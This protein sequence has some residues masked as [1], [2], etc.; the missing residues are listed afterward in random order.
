[1]VNVTIIDESVQPDYRMFLD[2]RFRSVHAE[3]MY[4]KATGRSENAVLELYDVRARRALIRYSF[5]LTAD[6]DA[7]RKAAREFVAQMRKQLDLKAGGK[8]AGSREDR[9]GAEQ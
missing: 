1:M 5:K 3:I 2:P 4:R 8:T 7:Q 9:S 6:E